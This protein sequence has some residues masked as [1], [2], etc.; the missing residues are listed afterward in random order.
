MNGHPVRLPWGVNVRDKI[1]KTVTLSNSAVGRYVNLSIAT[2]MHSWKLCTGGTVSLA[3]LIG[4]F[5]LRLF[6]AIWRVAM[7]HN[8]SAQSR[9]PTAA[10]GL[11]RSTSPYRVLFGDCA[12]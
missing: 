9:Q 11:Q 10:A 4:R 2:P 12:A 6:V 7:L 3:S 5:L 1:R 8:P